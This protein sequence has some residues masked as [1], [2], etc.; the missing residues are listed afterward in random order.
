MN[1]FL[2]N[3]LNV[4]DTVAFMQIGYRQLKRGEI[5][6][7]NEKKATIKPERGND[8]TYQFYSQIIKIPKDLIAG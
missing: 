6:K 2:G 7:L 5:V 4:G 8:N 3:E 1:D